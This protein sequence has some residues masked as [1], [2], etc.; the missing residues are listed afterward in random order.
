MHHNFVK[1]KCLIYLSTCEGVVTSAD[2]SQAC[3]VNIKSLHVLLQRW[4]RWGYV[5]RR[6]GYDDSENLRYLYWLAP[7]GREY[8]KG[9]IKWYPHLNEARLEVHLSMI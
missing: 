2:I 8:L 6:T 1:I 9:L 5:K 7:K 3:N 4:A